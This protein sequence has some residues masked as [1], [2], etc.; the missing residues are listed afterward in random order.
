MRHTLQAHQ[1]GLGYG[2]RLIV[3][4]LTVEVPSSRSSA[5][6]PPSSTIRSRVRRRSCRSV[7][8]I[9]RPPMPAYERRIVERGTHDELDAAV[10]LRR[11]LGGVEALPHSRPDLIRVLSL[12]KTVIRPS[13]AHGM[14]GRGDSAVV[15]T[16]RMASGGAVMI[17]RI[18]GLRRTHRPV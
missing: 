11:A 7:G 13:T 2:E 3:D 6:R 8:T 9:A 15:G 14:D 17:T 1:L 5:W 4:N 18:P 10:G 12:S 16:W